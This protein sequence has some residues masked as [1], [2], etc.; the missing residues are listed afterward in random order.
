MNEEDLRTALEA[1]ELFGS[2]LLGNADTH[3]IGVG[4]RRRA[5]EKLDE[6][7]VVV[8][9]ARKLPRDEVPPAR[10]LPREF[11]FVTR[12]GRPVVVPV[13]VQERPVPVPETRS[14]PAVPDLHSRL[15][16]VPGG[17]SA[18]TGT[19]GGWVWEI[20]ASR[21]VALSNEHVFGSAA[22]APVT[23]PSQ[24]DGGTAPGDRIAT[25]VRA[26]VLDAAI[27]VPDDP[28]VVSRSIAGSGAAVFEIADA[29]VDMRVRKCGK[30]TGITSGTVD[31]VDYVAGDGHHGSRSDVWI[32]GD[33]DFSAD[34][35]SGSLYLE[36]THP[37]PAT[38]W[39]RVVGLHWGGA[40][41]DGVGHHIRAVFADL[42]LAPLPPP[43]A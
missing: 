32:E 9:V 41:D 21:V 27:A 12:D 15:R 24:G 6:Y 16:P 42:G 37:D 18:A 13:D 30:T 5:G 2:S 7:A 20:G 22:G 28:E 10:L 38:G 4:R 8:H 39:L 25:V 34:G 31:L 33:D 11:R 40:G 19:L 1:K 14:A 36:A 26:G 35:D 17:S 3:G 29:T 43:P 23:Q